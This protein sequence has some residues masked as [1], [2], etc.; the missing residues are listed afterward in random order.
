MG[1]EY[2]PFVLLGVGY[3]MAVFYFIVDQAFLGGEWWLPL[4]LPVVVP[5][6]WVYEHWRGLCLTFA[7][8]ASLIFVPVLCVKVFS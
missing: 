5:V 4:V 8:L 1:F 6:M 2:W 3:W 7:V